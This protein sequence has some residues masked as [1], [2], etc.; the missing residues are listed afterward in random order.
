MLVWIIG[1]KIQQILETEKMFI[2][3]LKILSLIHSCDLELICVNCKVKKPRKI[4]FRF[5]FSNRKKYNCLD[6]LDLL[7][8]RSF[9]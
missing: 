2:E 7:C 4:R 5:V 9:K 6:M 3:I 1:R 8:N